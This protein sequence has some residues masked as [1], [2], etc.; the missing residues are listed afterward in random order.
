MRFWRLRVPIHRMWLVTVWLLAIVAG[1][2]VSPLGGDAFAS[3]AWLLLGV[4]LLIMSLTKA[5]TWMVALALVGGL[6]VGLSRGGL[7]QLHRHV[8]APAF[9]QIVTIHGV[10]SEDPDLS[11]RH[12][13][14]LRLKSVGSGDRSLPGDMWVTTG[15]TNTIRRSDVVTVTGKLQEG[16][17]SFAASMYD[18]QLVRVERPVPGDVAL[19]LR[20]EFASDVRKGV[21]EPEASLGIGFLTGQRRALPEELDQ[22]LRVA[23]LMHIVVASGYNLTI[24]VR[25]TKRLFEKRSRYLVVYSSMMLI[26]GFILVT[27]L[28]PSMT[29]AGLVATLSLMAWYFGRK[30]HPVTLIAFAAALTGI[31]D[32]SY[33]WGNLGWQ[34]SFAAFAGVMVLAPLLQAYFFGDKKPGIIRQVMGETISAQIMTVPLILYNFGQLSN[35]AVV[36]NLLV[37]P[38]VPLAMLLTFITGVLGA[39]GPSVMGIVA[40]PTQWLLDY[41][42]WVTM[43]LANLSWAQSD[44]SL[45]LGGM[46]ACFAVIIGVIVYLRRA[47][48]YDLRQ[49]NLVE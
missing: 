33:V 32:P 14:V 20:D 11:K 36:A 42:V 9:G 27:G 40:A 23:G 24:L 19:E 10:V 26:I 43:S 6:L 2:A 34:L 5:R 47:S 21:D 30:F 8:Y 41:M 46:I 15:D 18:A 28:S 3:W 13:T 16:S 38:L 22:S 1:L 7:D 44:V 4:L 49:A 31:I 45:S 37:L 12:Q 17:G 35:V 48:G 39:I 25:L 29:R